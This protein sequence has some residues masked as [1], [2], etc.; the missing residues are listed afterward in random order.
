MDFAGVFINFVARQTFRFSYCVIFVDNILFRILINN[1]DYSIIRSRSYLLV[2]WF[3]KE[4][5]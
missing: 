1:V 2:A 4:N 3:K 5:N